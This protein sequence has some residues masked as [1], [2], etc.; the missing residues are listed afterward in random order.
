MNNDQNIQKDT[1]HISVFF[2]PWEMVGKLVGIFECIPLAQ[3]LFPTKKYVFPP[4]PTNLQKW[5]NKK[6]IFSS[7]KPKKIGGGRKPKKKFSV[8]KKTLRHMHNRMVQHLPL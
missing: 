6:N 1:R 8:G 4:F 7:G 2:S 5:W 3:P